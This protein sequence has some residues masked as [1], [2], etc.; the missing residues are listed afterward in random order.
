MVQQACLFIFTQSFFDIFL[1]NTQI[2]K[3]I[4]K[5]SKRMNSNA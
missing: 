3:P 1:P 4:N 2:H 5:I